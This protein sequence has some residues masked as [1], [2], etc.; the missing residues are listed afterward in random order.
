MRRDHHKKGGMKPFGYPRHVTGPPTENGRTLLLALDAVP[1]RVVEESRRRGA[2]R[3][4]PS[5]SVVV[6]P[7]PTVT[8]VAF[9]SLFLPFGVEPSPRYELRSFDADANVM[10]GGSPLHYRADVPPWTAFLDAPHRSLTSELSNYVSPRHAANT[11]VDEIEQTLLTSERDVII[12]Y[13]GATDGIMHLYGDEAAVEF[14][15]ELDVRLSAMSRRNEQVTGGPL[16]FALFSDHGCGSCRIRHAN[17]FDDLLRA[18]GFRV[19]EH[20][21]RPADVVNPNYGVINFGTLFLHDSERAEAAANA[22]AQQENTEIAAFSLEPNSVDVVSRFG[23]ARVRW[24]DSDGVRYAYEDG[25]GDP[26]RLGTVRDDLIARNLMDDSGF[27][28]DGEW[29]RGTA[30]E[31]YPDVLHRLAA[32]LTGDRVQSRA[33][34]I[35]SLDPCWARG[36]R[37]AVAGSWVRHGP[38]KGTHGG[39]DRDSTHA[40]YLA[41]DPAL[42]MPPVVRSEE[43]LVPFACDS[44][45]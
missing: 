7:F 36:I 29:L 9:A 25:G 24:R 1:F 45:P 31:Y 38:L 35:Y 21:E 27:A 5:P 23:R 8:H 12:G 41:S 33:N 28:A 43:L 10:K 16:R 6:A 32:A 40:F 17:G 30:F 37:S 15:L 13:V 2:F 4:W 44:P 18:S 42:A 14:L 22:V 26:L 20:L 39:L 11:K 3:G 34:V 19:V